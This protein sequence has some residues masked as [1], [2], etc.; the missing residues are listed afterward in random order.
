MLATVANCA[1]H[2]RFGDNGKM[3]SSAIR[4]NSFAPWKTA[5]FS[6]M[7]AALL[8]GCLGRGFSLPSFG[9]SH[10]RSERVQEASSASI[11]MPIRSVVILATALEVWRQI[12]TDNA[13]MHPSWV[14]KFQSTCPLQSHA[15]QLFEEIP[16]SFTTAVIELAAA[17]A[18][19]VKADSSVQQIEMDQD[20]LSRWVDAA[21]ALSA[22]HDCHLTAWE[23]VD[24]EAR[25][26][27]RS[28]TSGA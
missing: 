8:A 22:K 25:K 13:Q 4:R 26:A 9:H 21:S 20:R 5:V 18:W 14:F 10:H 17:E 28:V 19:L 12:E 7:C 6:V 2:G 23:L 16:K 27:Y 3:R 1:L 24:V 15:Q 11:A